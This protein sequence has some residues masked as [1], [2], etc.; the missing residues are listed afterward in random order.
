M[1]CSGGLGGLY[2]DQKITH[3]LNIE[4]LPKPRLTAAGMDDMISSSFM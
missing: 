4:S 2:T 1:P 3:T